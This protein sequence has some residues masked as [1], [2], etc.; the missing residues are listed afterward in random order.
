MPAW[1]WIA[2]AATMP[3]VVLALP[4]LATACDRTSPASPCAGWTDV[5]MEP[6]DIDAISDTLAL[7]LKQHHQHFKD[8]CG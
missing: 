7:W 2:R 5:Q 3:C 4:L 8:S 1:R 6:Q